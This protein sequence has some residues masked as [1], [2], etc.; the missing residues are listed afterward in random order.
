MSKYYDEVDLKAARKENSYTSADLRDMKDELN[1]PCNIAL[2]EELEEVRL[3][4]G[5]DESVDKFVRVFRRI[6]DSDRVF[7][8]H[9]AEI[10]RFVKKCLGCLSG[11][12]NLKDP[13]DADFMLSVYHLIG[14]YN[15]EIFEKVRA[16][17]SRSG[18]FYDTSDESVSKRELVDIK[19]WMKKGLDTDLRKEKITNFPLVFLICLHHLETRE[20]DSLW[21]HLM[22]TFP[23]ISEKPKRKRVKQNRVRWVD[24]KPVNYDQIVDQLKILYDCL[25]DILEKRKTSPGIYQDMY[26]KC[27]DKI[28]SREAKLG[29]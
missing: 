9:K 28:R 26:V 1:N 5:N 17:V 8:S 11:Y 15:P 13:L 29:L 3:W 10:S 6:L 16:A 27:M 21:M 20:E 4:I 25:R 7:D 23:I 14:T 18:L 19:K 2:R 22:E 24:A 12:V